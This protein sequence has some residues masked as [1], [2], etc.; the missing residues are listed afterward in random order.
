MHTGK[1]PK[2]F[3]SPLEFYNAF[4]DAC[5][6]WFYPQPA[7]WRNLAEDYNDGMIIHFTRFMK[8]IRYTRN[9]AEG[10]TDRQTKITAAN[11][12][13]CIL[14]HAVKYSFSNACAKKIPDYFEA[15]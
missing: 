13:L 10:R 4:C 7:S 6:V 12:E 8:W 14:R 5:H 2:V 3:L 9:Y 15:P 1:S 11:T